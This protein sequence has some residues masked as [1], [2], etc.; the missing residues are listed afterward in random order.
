MGR[1]HFATAIVCSSCAQAGTVDCE[2]IAEI[3]P[4]HARS[5]LIGLSDGFY[6]APRATKFGD[7]QIICN[8]CGAV[9]KHWLT[10]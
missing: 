4:A 6:Q 5:I 3:D 1:E 9:Q 2:R 7:P 8:L 10:L